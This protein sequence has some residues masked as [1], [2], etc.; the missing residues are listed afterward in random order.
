MD[1]PLAFLSPTEWSALWLSFQVALVAALFSL[2][3]AVAAG[4]V[5]AR[6][7]FIGKWI[8]EILIDLPLVLPPVVTGYLLLVSFA[9]HGTIGAILEQVVWNQDCIYLA[10]GGTGV[11]C[12]Q[13]P[14]YGPRDPPCVSRGRSPL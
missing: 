3:L 8:V 14:A 5:L 13:F 7:H 10:G 4:Y 11:G 6:F 1:T 2:P 9:P 12:R